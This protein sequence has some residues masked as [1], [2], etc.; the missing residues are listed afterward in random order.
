[1]RRELLLERIDKLKATM[2]WYILEYYQSKLAVP[3]S[4]TTL[5]EYLKEYDR[6]FNW[7]LESGITD[8]SHIAEIPL[9]VLENM[10]KKDINALE[11]TAAHIV[12]V[13]AQAH[14]FVHEA[15]VAASHRRDER[16]TKKSIET[17]KRIMSVAT[18]IMVERG[19]TDFKM[20]E[21]SS[22][23]QLSKGALYYYF[24]DKDSLVQAVFDSS[25]DDLADVLHQ[26]RECCH[27]V[28]KGIEGRISVLNVAIGQ[29]V[30]C[31]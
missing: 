3:Y 2:P 29:L 8:A 5:Y 1:M 28:G 4:F 18:K 10:S 9:S 19:S 15:I 7:V 27:A 31:A 11:E 13:H 25:V 21:V 20:S 17:R 24:A 16:R 14:E 26:Y 30:A 23:A 22:Q 12:A 6:F